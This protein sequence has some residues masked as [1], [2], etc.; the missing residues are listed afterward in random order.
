MKDVM[1]ELHYSLSIVSFVVEREFHTRRGL[2]GLWGEKEKE[3][4]VIKA[5]S[6]C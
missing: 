2:K 4:C 1:F 5:K 6:R 3:N